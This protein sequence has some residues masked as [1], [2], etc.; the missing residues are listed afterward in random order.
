DQYLNVA[1][2][3][4][5]SG[6]LRANGLILLEL[7][8]LA[9]VVHQEARHA[10]ELILLRRQYAHRE[11]FSGQVGAWQL[12]AL[13]GIGFILVH[14]TRRLVG[15]PRLQLLDG[16]GSDLVVSLAWGVVIGCHPALSF[17]P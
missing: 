17:S 6:A 13:C 4:S 2:A 11:F 5:L 16:V 12:E 15:T 9:A 7:R 8:Q 1:H 14:H 10:R 3:I